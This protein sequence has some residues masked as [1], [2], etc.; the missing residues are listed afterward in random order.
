MINIKQSGIY[1]KGSW[2]A[3]FLFCTILWSF[4]LYIIKIL[5]RKH[6][7]L[8]VIGYFL[9]PFFQFMTHLKTDL[10]NKNILKVNYLKKNPM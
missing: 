5:H 4:H 9:V 7:H 6:H 10:S 3:C 2:T 8:E 1:L